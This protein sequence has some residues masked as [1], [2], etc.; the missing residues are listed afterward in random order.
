MKYLLLLLLLFSC[1]HS[2]HQEGSDFS[3]NPQAKVGTPIRG[4]GSQTV[5][6][7]FATNTDYVDEAMKDL[8][9]K[10]S[11]VISPVSTQFYTD[12]GFLHWT[13]HVVLDGTCLR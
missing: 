11:G 2:F 3:L 8:E 9:G 13:N 10:C 7:G 4:I 5:I 12:L 1:A 6:L